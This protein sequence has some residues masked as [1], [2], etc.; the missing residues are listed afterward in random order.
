MCFDRNGDWVI[1]GTTNSTSFPLLNPLQSQF[2][3]GYSDAFV[4]VLDKGLA[5]LKFSTYLGGTDYDEAGGVFVDPAGTTLVVG[6]TRS[7]N[8]P[9][10]APQ[11]STLDGGKEDV[12]ITS[13]ATNRTSITWS[14][15]Y[16]GA[17]ADA[18]TRLESTL[19]YDVWVQVE[20]TGTSFPLL[21]GFLSSGDDDALFR[22]NFPSLFTPPPTNLQAQLLSL[23]SIRLT[24]NDPGNLET[25]FR[26]QRSVD[27][28]GWEDPVTIG[29]NVT[30]LD[31]SGL[32]PEG[33][34]E[35][36]VSA[37]NDLA[38][39][40][41]SEPVFITMPS[42][43]VLPPADPSNLQVAVLS[44]REALL[45]WQDNSDNE[46]FFLLARAEGSGLFTTLATPGLG[47]TSFTDDSL[48]PERT[49]SWK[50]R[51]QN[52]VGTS[53]FSNTVSVT[54]PSTLEVAIT[55]G[56]IVD[57]ADV[58]SKDAV[59]LA[60]TLGY[61]E[62]SQH[63]VFDPSNQSFTLRIGAF[64]DPAIL[65]IPVPADGWVL[66][67]GKYNWKS[68]KG[69]AVKAKVSVDPAAF[70]WTVKLT[71]LTLAVPTTNPLRVTLTLGTDTGHVD[72]DWTAPTKSGVIKFP[73]PVPK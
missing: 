71:G 36:R 57:K 64:G 33:S 70:T 27:A 9:L 51:C 2:G 50:V 43:P 44:P 41:Y 34:Y 16:G 28:G 20:G 32:A 45:T 52:P 37:F 48:L 61:V 15:F 65:S 24:W 21:N 13:Y 63:A 54:L 73:V 5:S 66:K 6:T 26:V 39:S 56:K 47:T 7:G 72:G 29:A 3:G 35:F 60:G 22:I 62:G 69:S 30:G 58:I 38:E 59:T 4:A 67:K 10:V 40:A 1:T 17:G 46:D 19:D 42:T 11:D 31:V 68:P 23:T 12:F 25:G 49:Y 18:A 55:K 14:T 8:F 53:L